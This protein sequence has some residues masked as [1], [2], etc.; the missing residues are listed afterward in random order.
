VLTEETKS[1]SSLNLAA[2]KSVCDYIGIQTEITTSS[3]DYN[4]KHLKAEHRILDICEQES[5][6]TY[7]NPS[8]GIELYDKSTFLHKNINL[9]FLKSNNIAYNQNK[10]EFIPWLS[11][12]DLLMCLDKDELNNYLKQY[13]LT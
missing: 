2:I 9:Q 11:I 13:Q 8:G 4:N 7:I 3:A 10:N 1:I 6:D 5:A 12:I